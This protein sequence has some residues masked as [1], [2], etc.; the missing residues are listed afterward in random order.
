MFISVPVLVPVAAPLT[1]IIVGTGTGLATVLLAYLLDEVDAFGVRRD[2]EAQQIDALLDDR[3]DTAAE[4]LA[5]E[6]NDPVFAEL[7]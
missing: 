3:L 4:R 2:G 1:I 6:L 7:V 5:A